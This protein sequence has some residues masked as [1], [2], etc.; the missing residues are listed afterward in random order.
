M[1]KSLIVAAVLA[2]ALAGCART[3]ANVHVISTT[4]CGAT[5]V[6]LDVASS[7][8][9]HTGNVCVTIQHSLTGQWLAMHNSRRSLPRVFYRM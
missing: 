1:K 4:D 2:I 8:P 9:K 3:P 5:W 6:K 7:I